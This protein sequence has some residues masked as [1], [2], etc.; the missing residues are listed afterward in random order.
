MIVPPELD[1]SLFID[2]H[3]DQDQLLVVLGNGFDLFHGFKSRYQDFW[4]HVGTTPL[5][6]IV[7][8]N[9]RARSQQ[10][11][12]SDVEAQ[13]RVA[14]ENAYQLSATRK[15]PGAGV[16][17]QQRSTR[18][19]RRFEHEFSRYLRTERERVLVS[20]PTRSQTAREFLSQAGAVLNFNY[21]DTALIR[22]SSCMTSG[23]RISTICMGRFWKVRPF[24]GLTMM[25]CWHA[26]LM[27]MPVRPRATSATFLI[28]NAGPGSRM[29]GGRLMKKHWPP[30]ETMMP[31]IMV[32]G[33]C[34]QCLAI[35]R[36]SRCYIRLTATCPL[37]AA[38]LQLAFLSSG[39]HGASG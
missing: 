1:Q 25:T 29:A 4:Q 19:I 18:A 37:P 3:H 22:R 8:F 20:D 13:I 9:R 10:V 11:R 39:R 28:L 14:A 7:H 34:T 17:V 6:E 26:S 27:N 24:L 5:D 16:M 33:A 35:K 36:L 23:Q 38:I 32:G 15:M 31:I 12:W 2:Q 21:T 30:F